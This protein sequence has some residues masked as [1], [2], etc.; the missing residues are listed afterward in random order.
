MKALKWE[1]VK[2]SPRRDVPARIEGS[3]K[4]SCLVYPRGK[5]DKT[6][7]TRFLGFKLFSIYQDLTPACFGAWSPGAFA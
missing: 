6:D 2:P 3:E 1:T 4:L 5:K 7:K